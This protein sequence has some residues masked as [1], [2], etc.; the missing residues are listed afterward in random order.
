[1]NHAEDVNPCK[2]WLLVPRPGTR[3]ALHTQIQR[4]TVEEQHAHMHG[5]GQVAG[6]AG[7]AQ[8][9]A[10]AAEDEEEGDADFEE[11]VPVDCGGDMELDS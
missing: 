10:E 1:M 6:S 8:S 11:D 4:L 7:A 3:S 2:W 5:T 9:I